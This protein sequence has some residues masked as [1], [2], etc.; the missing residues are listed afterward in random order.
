MNL[1]GLVGLEGGA[2]TAGLEVKV[3]ELD[4]YLRNG[5]K[6]KHP[7]EQR[8]PLLV[9]QPNPTRTVELPERLEALNEPEIVQDKQ[10]ETS[11]SERIQ[12]E[13]TVKKNSRK[14]KLEAEG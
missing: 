1:E 3:E 2:G 6:S 7:N 14:R 9:P 11:E 5:T 10:N 8:S 13:P 4:T 12:K